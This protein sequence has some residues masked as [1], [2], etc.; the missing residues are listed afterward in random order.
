MKRVLIQT[1][2]KTGCW[3]FCLCYSCDII[4]PSEASREGPHPHV[5]H[6]VYEVP[7]A[8]RIHCSLHG[9][10][11]EPADCRDKNKP[12]IEWKKNNNFSCP[13]LKRTPSWSFSN[14]MDM[15]TQTTWCVERSKAETDPL[16]HHSSGSNK[17]LCS[18]CNC[19]AGNIDVNV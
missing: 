3:T 8:R 4:P 11:G 15:Y 7:E 1:H 18:F 10:N 9:T 6:E 2:F 14:M 5:P 16:D 17:D 12:F 19:S 13:F